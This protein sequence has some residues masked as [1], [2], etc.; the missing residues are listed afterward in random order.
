MNIFM[1]KLHM[2]CVQKIL[3]G[4]ILPP[5]NFDAKAAQQHRLTLQ[6]VRFL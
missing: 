6:F 3:L 1:P 5:Y 4:R 2:L